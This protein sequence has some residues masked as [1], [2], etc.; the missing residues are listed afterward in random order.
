MPTGFLHK[1]LNNLLSRPKYGLHD[2]YICLE[3]HV[4]AYKEMLGM[5]N[6]NRAGPS[7]NLKIPLPWNNVPKLIIEVNHLSLKIQSS[8]MMNY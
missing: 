2:D 6:L 8:N 5:T 7:M 4:V 3:E 1:D